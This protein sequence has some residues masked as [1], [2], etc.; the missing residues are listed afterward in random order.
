MLRLVQISNG[1]SRRLALVE[2]PLLHCLTTVESV[3]ELALAS[4]REGTSLSGWA[5]D[6]A[7]GEKLSYDAVYS[8]ESEWGLLVPVD[9][10]NA[11][12]RVLV[13]G[14]GLTHLGSAKDRQAMHLQTATDAAKPKTEMP[15]KEPKPD[16]CVTCH[17]PPHVEQFDAKA[18]MAEILGPGHGL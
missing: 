15:R 10:P 17:H 1:L 6:L 8:G 14:T 9:V 4:V 2:E 5:R 3:Y 7:T 13:T 16:V 11:P 12:E 18:K